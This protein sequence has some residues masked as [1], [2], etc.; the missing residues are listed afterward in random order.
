MRHAAH[1]ASAVEVSP[2]RCGI[3]Q[4]VLPQYQQCRRC[5]PVAPTTPH[6]QAAAHRRRHGQHQPRFAHDGGC[7]FR[8]PLERCVEYIS[9]AT[10]RRAAGDTSTGEHA[11]PRAPL[12]L[13]ALHSNAFMRCGCWR[14]HPHGAGS[15]ADS[16]TG[17]PGALPK[18]SFRY[19]GWRHDSTTAPRLATRPR[20]TSAGDALGGDKQPHGGSIEHARCP[21]TRRRRPEGWPGSGVRPE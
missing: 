8:P 5:G 9:P 17:V 15:A 10:P 1:S 2:A 20:R 19:F 18:R 3:P 11:A 13:T 16:A 14:H 6:T 4:T 12:A 21:R 7:L